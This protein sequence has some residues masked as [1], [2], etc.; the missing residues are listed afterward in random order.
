M[1]QVKTGTVISNKMVGTVV[2]K[3]A[4]RVKHPLY[5]KMVTKSKNFKAY[6]PIG[7]KIGQK[8][9]IIETR[10]ISGDVHFEVL[11]GMT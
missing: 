9:K 5:K 7:A 4:S 1:P 11:E 2:V 10:P 3:V 8:V 6:D